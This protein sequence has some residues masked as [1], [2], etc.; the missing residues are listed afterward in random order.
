MLCSQ[1]RVAISPRNPRSK[2]HDLARTQDW[3]T[4][5]T[6]PECCLPFALPSA[7]PSTR[8]PLRMH[9]PS[10]GWWRGS[11]DSLHTC[12]PSPG[13]CMCRDS[14]RTGLSDELET[15]CTCVNL[16]LAGIVQRLSGS[17]LCWRL[18]TCTSLGLAGMCVEALQLSTR[19]GTDPKTLYTCNSL[20]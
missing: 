15:M 13:W 6:V 5:W 3:A 14:I 20:H 12:Q 8:D 7:E 4:L 17:A 18:C 2:D 1:T 16:R 10:P 11:R 19:L 9:K